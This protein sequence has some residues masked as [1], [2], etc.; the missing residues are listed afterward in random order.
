[1]LF[2]DIVKYMIIQK[3]IDM[4]DNSIL[5]VETILRFNNKLKKKENFCQVSMI[6]FKISYY[7]EYLLFS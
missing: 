3:S 7:F 5:C 4:R 1:M 6:D 2:D